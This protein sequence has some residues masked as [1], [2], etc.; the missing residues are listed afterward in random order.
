MFDFV[1]FDMQKRVGKLDFNI[2][3][4]LPKVTCEQLLIPCVT[5]EIIEENTIWAHT[6][7]HFSTL[8]ACLPILRPLVQDNGRM[9]TILGSIRSLITGRSPPAHSES[10]R[11]G[12]FNNNG[13]LGRSNL[14]TD[15]D[16]N[17]NWYPLKPGVNTQIAAVPRSQRSKDG[18]M[19]S[20]TILVKTKFV[21]KCVL[22][23]PA[24]IDRIV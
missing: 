24:D 10:T 18:S 5:P 22:D 9:Q 3:V 4:C 16:R 2:H 8:T 7:A 13:V 15:S 23:G 11:H 14:S 19:N 6:E 12:G 21:T 1:R 20:D 17:L